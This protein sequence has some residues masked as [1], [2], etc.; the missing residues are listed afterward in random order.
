MKASLITA[1]LFVSTISISW[2]FIEWQ[3]YGI[4]ADHHLTS[5][6]QANVHYFLM[7]EHIEYCWDEHDRINAEHKYI[8]TVYLHQIRVGPGLSYAD[9]DKMVKSDKANNLYGQILDCEDSLKSQKTDDLSKH[10][11]LKALV[12]LIGD[13]HQPLQIDINEHYQNQ[14]FTAIEGS[15]AHLSKLW[16]S[17]LTD[18]SRLHSTQMATAYDNATTNQIDQWQHDDL[19]QW[20][21]E[22]YL[23]RSQLNDNIQRQPNKQFI[24]DFISNGQKRIVQAGIRLAST[25]NSIYEESYRYDPYNDLDFVTGQDLGD[26]K[27]ESVYGNTMSVRGIVINL[28]KTD[29]VIIVE[30]KHQWYNHEN[31][32]YNSNKITAFLK[33]RSIQWWKSVELLNREIIVTGKLMSIKGKPGIN[34]TEPNRI[35]FVQYFI[36][37]VIKPVI[38]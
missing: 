22:S 35:S 19:M 20:L 25:L 31:G 1:I 24:R 23:L 18:R 30:L 14:N 37:P 29:S 6:A 5:V 26:E 16:D 17:L 13:A 11:A 4:V 36:D 27:P 12:H 10:Y 21:Y 9:F 15:E 2:N 3:T 8:K 32:D 34:I 7:N 38:K 28:K 33:G